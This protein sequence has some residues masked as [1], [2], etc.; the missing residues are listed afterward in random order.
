MSRWSKARYSSSIGIEIGFGGE[1]E[2]K[3][4]PSPWHDSTLVDSQRRCGKYQSSLRACSMK[5]VNCL[6]R[7][8]EDADEDEDAARSQ[9]GGKDQEEL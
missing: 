1:L 2:D 4:V 3:V 7:V 8:L 5:A 9:K 6:S